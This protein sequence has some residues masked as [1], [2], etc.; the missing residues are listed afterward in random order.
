MKVRLDD[1]HVARRGRR[2]YGDVAA[3]ASDLQLNGQITPITLRPP[4]PEEIADGITKPYVLVAGGRRLAAATVSGWDDIEAY[5]REEMDSITHLVLELHENLKREAL[6]W[7]E[8]ANMR[9]EIMKLRQIQE[10]GITAYEVAAEIGDTQSTFSRNVQ[11]AEAM[12]ADP[13]LAQAP[14]RKAALRAVD[15]SNE[16]KARRRRDESNK[17]ALDELSDRIVCADMLEWLPQF[18]NTFDLMIPDLPYGIDFHKAGQKT[19]SKSK[20]RY[21]DS[22]KSMRQL[23]QNA[24]PL[25]VR[26]T[27]PSGWI[28]AFA[29]Y[30]SHLLLTRMFSSICSTHY[31]YKGETKQCEN[32]QSDGEPCV[33][34][35]PAT[36]P[37]IWYRPNSINN[38]RYPHHTA[39]NCYEPIVVVNMGTAMLTEKVDNVLVHEAE[40]GG[41]RTHENQKPL[42]LIQDLVN[43]TTYAG[44]YVCDPCFGSGAHLA[45]ASSEGRVV[46]GCDSDESRLAPALGL[47]AKHFKPA[48]VIDRDVRDEILRSRIEKLTFRVEDQ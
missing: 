32:A 13:S 23:V 36:I 17:A 33:Y 43:R 27:K 41:D 29:S 12:I 21:D 22:N 19:K 8:E 35:K 3:L 25:M 39:K 26:A 16:L 46:F 45:A 28:I 2:E 42:E 15:V 44:D 20:A 11:A 48:P 9:N 10:P 31:G 30:E 40:Y 7:Q 5:A 4:T 47:V 37:W 24:L 18:E 6:T 34:L 14:S 1:I 38:P